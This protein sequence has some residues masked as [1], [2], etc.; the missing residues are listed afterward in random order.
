M[1]TFEHNPVNPVTR[2]IVATCPFDENA[3]LIA[4]PELRRRQARAGFS[5]VEVRYTGFFPGALAALR[6]LERLMTALP[7]GA[8]YYTFARA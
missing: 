5:A 2:H 1:A 4:A 6:P 7:L 3:H 8:Q